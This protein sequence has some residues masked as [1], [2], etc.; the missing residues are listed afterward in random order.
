[1][2][3]RRFNRIVTVKK[4]KARQSRQHPSTRKLKLGWPNLPA[5]GKPSPPYRV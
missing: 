2:M 4:S 1:M 5:D 3:K